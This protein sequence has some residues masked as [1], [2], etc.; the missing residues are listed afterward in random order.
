[1]PRVFGKNVEKVLTF[2]VLLTNDV[3]I[4]GLRNQSEEKLEL[5]FIQCILH[6]QHIVITI[7]ED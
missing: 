5:I 3:V 1:M 4:R 2:V 7:V 6:G